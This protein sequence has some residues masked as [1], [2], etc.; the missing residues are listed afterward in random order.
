[1]INAIHFYK[2]HFNKGDGIT[3]VVTNISKYQNEISNINSIELPFSSDDKLK[4]NEI[5]GYNTLIG[6]LILAIKHKPNLV[7]LHG[8]FYPQILILSFIFGML[9]KKIILVP[10]CS[11]LNIS[12]NR[13]KIK[14]IIY[15][16]FFKKIALNRISSIQYLN[17][18]EKENSYLKNDKLNS[19][20]L[21]NGV[22]E[23]PYNKKNFDK[24]NFFYLGRCDVYHKGIDIL[25][26]G[27]SHVNPYYINEFNIF[28]ASLEEEAKIKKI[29]SNIPNNISIKIHPPIFN[30]DKDNILS[31]Y[32]IYIMTS[33]Y[34]GLPVSVI[35]ALSYGCICLLSEGTNLSKLVEKYG[36]GYEINDAFT[37]SNAVEK[38]STLSQSEL[39]HM[40]D[41]AKNLVADNFLWRKIA[42]ESVNFYQNLIETDSRDI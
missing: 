30:Q 4:Q 25:I 27:I 33:R 39:M 36:C 41:K 34:E 15:L 40:S 2:R 8:I 17:S 23:I 22:S 7:I 37:I 14:K 1:M 42:I 10:H 6:M 21:Y 18:F 3:T 31:E 29:I 16:Y 5:Y 13:K 26:K 19:F 38:I 35:E 32:N 28:G 11:L 12:V 20:I 24:L 9:G